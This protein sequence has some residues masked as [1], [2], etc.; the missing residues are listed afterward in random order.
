[1]TWIRE[2]AT[3]VTAGDWSF[4]L[5]DDDISTIRFH[6]VDVL[7][8]VRAVARDRNWA[9][10]QWTISGVADVPGG[11]RMSLRTRQLGADL[12]ASLTATADGETLTVV[13]EATSAV[14]FPTNRTGL[15]VLHPPQLAGSAL[16]IEHADGTEDTTA[17]PVDIAPL[18]PAF[19][20]RSLV[21]EQEGLRVTCTFDGDVFEMEDQRNWTDASFKTYSRPLALPFPYLLAAGETVRQSVSVTAEA[22]PD[23]AVPDAVAGTAA[24]TSGD[25]HAAP[26]GAV[27]TAAGAEAL[28]FVDAGTM[29]AVSVGASTAPDAGPVPVPV[30]ADL[31]VEIDLGWAGWP[32][33]LARAAGSGLPL[34]VRLVLPEADAATAVRDAARA[35]AGLEIARVTA[36]RPAG[37]DAQHVSDAG[38]IALLRAAL[39]EAGV[40]V[41]IVGG[42][43]SHFTE[44][45][46][47]HHRLPAELDGVVFSLTPTFHAFETLQVEQSI[48]MQRLVAEQAV[49]IAGGAPVHV[50][51]ITLRAHVNN[52]ATAAPARPSVADL[53][54]GYGPELLDADDPRQTDP[55]LAAWVIASATA[56][57]VP[58]VATVSFFEEWGPRGIRTASGDDLPAAEAIR[59]L[60]A[61][62]GAALQT[63]HTS[64]ER[65]WALRAGDTTLAA[66]LSDAARMVVIDG[67]AVTLDPRAWRR[68]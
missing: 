52:V 61:L 59:A 11:I 15:V 38:A 42:A 41:P 43:R 51:P 21:W 2:T 4:E 34:D 44:L 62:N 50:G 47:E 36:F 39:T 12:D 17:F 8:S 68:L 63:A 23:V 27:A 45:N 14:E 26:A 16:R 24:A 31:L 7:R 55:E 40:T 13:F 60:A 30:G 33:A 37:H 5:R 66:S 18:Q 35:L 19:D 64:D 28:A 56:L 54:D 29:P 58:G 9:T 10:P 57:S 32:A 1:M 22:V 20:I 65:I 67:R 53:S 3:P 6:G 46:R 48:A 25:A 49:R